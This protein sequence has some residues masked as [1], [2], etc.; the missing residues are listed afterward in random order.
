MIVIPQVTETS[1]E[2]E[3]RLSEIGRLFGIEDG[4]AMFRKIAGGLQRKHRD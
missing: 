1:A 2:D 3:K 4:A